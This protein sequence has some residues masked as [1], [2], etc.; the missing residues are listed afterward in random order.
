[1]GTKG[2][3]LTAAR[4][5]RLPWGARRG[6]ENRVGRSTCSSAQ[7]GKTGTVWF[8]LQRS[9][10]DRKGTECTRSLPETPAHPAEKKH[11]PADGRVTVSSVEGWCRF[12]ESLSQMGREIHKG[13]AKPWVPQVRAEL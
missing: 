13:L 12:I 4:E 7:E 1:M 10:G 11:P 3:L 6:H 5:L 2:P 8:L 9:R